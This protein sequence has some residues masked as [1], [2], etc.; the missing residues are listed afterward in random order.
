M[1]AIQVFEKLA[2]KYDEWYEKYPFV[3]QSEIAALSS[4]VPRK[5]RALK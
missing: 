1:E 3:Y 4:F 5:G 2:K